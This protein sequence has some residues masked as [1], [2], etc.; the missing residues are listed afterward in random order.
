M[1]NILE[2][3][4]YPDWYFSAYDFDWFLCD[5]IGQVACMVSIGLRV[6]TSI[7]TA[8]PKDYQKLQ[9]YINSLPVLS[10]ELILS[11]FIQKDIT[12]KKNHSTPDLFISVFSYF[13]VRGIYAFN[14]RINSMNSKIFDLIATPQKSLNINAL[15]IEFARIIS[16]TRLKTS[17]TET[18]II[19][20]N[21]LE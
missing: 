20:I 17:L 5:P 7:R 21:E 15:P 9:N 11:D 1:D 4:Q 18:L 12:N 2:L 10:N 13:S 6:P 14:P 3:E 8:V 16:N 19:D